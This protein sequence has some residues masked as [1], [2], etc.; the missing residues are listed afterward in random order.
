LISYFAFVEQAISNEKRK[1]QRI[2][3]FMCEFKIRWI[4]K[5]IG[6]LPRSFF[7]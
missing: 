6:A 2:Y 4:E 1:R 5:K 3:L 7:N